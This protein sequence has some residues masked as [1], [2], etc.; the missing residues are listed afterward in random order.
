MIK[1]LQSIK[2]TQCLR[3]VST[4]GCIWLLICLHKVSERHTSLL[5]I[6]PAQDKGHEGKPEQGHPYPYPY[7][8]HHKHTLVE[9]S[10]N[11]MGSHTNRRNINKGCKSFLK[12]C[13]RHDTKIERRIPYYLSLFFK[14]QP[15]IENARQ[16]KTVRIGPILKK[17]KRAHS[18]TTNHTHTHLTNQQTKIRHQAKKKFQ[19][20]MVYSPSSQRAHYFFVEQISVTCVNYSLNCDVWICAFW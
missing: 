10:P 18:Q 19:H 16:K 2:N 6:P 3:S 12:K 7:V 15:V 20:K 1:I 9:L 13:K 17:P 8:P 14:I 11:E 5:N 4:V